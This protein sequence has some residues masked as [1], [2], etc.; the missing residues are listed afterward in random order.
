MS[1]NKML[2]TDWISI[3]LLV[4]GGLNWGVAVF[5]INLV[6]FAI[7]MVWLQKTVYGLVGLSAVYTII[8]GIVLASN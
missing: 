8:R 1:K 6:T 2:F 4:I 3:V 7:P 5:D